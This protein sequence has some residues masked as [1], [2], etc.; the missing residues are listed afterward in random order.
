MRYTFYAVAFPMIKASF[1]W[2]KNK[3]FDLKM[4]K[5]LTL[6]T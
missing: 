5:K 4:Q 3:K 6:L 2:S 1:Y